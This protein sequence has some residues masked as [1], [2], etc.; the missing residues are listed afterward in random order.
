MAFVNS[1]SSNIKTIHFLKKSLLL[2]HN[3]CT[4]SRE[5]S[6]MEYERRAEDTLVALTEYLD[7]LPDRVDCESAFDVSY[8]MGVLTAHISPR[9]GTYVI[10]KQ[11]P[12]KQI[13]LS[14]PVSGPKRYD[15]SDKGRWVYKH[16]GVTLHE[17]LEKEFRHIFKNDQ[18]SLQQS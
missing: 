6:E 16:D 18:I 11:T 9:I 3:Y 13:W 8:S 1:L 15:L 7:T 17:L 5:W 14:S 4:F 10:N 12:N 2:A